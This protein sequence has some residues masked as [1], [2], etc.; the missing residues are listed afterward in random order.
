MVAGLA[1]G[2]F[3]LRAAK[4]VAPRQYSDDELRAMSDD[5]WRKLTTADFHKARTSLLKVYRGQ[6]ARLR[7]QIEAKQG[8]AFEALSEQGQRRSLESEQ[9]VIAEL[10]R[11]RVFES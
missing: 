11:R 4:A 1:W 9:L 5:D 10:K 6:Y 3:R 2:W 7:Q 8:P